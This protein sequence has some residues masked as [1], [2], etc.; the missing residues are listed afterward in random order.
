M[1]GVRGKAARRLKLLGVAQEE[2]QVQPGLEALAARTQ[3]KRL[4][5]GQGF[6]EGLVQGAAQHHQG[7]GG[8][9]GK[10]P[11]AQGQKAVLI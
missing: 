5:I 10:T 6:L 4:Q 1:G 8:I 3:E 2:H 11:G 9:G 7:G